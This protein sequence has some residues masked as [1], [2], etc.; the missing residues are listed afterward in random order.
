[1]LLAFKRSGLL[2]ALT[3]CFGLLLGACGDNT[4]TTAP[5]ATTAASTTAAATTSAATAAAAT[6]ASATTQAATTQAAATT[7]SATTAAAT[8]AAPTTAAASATTA[9]ASGA[10]VKLTLALDWTPNTNHTGIYVALQKGWYKDAGIDLQLLP[11]ADGTIPDVLVGQGKA[12]LGISGADSVAT[13][14]AAGQPVVSI[15]AIMQ[16][17]TSGF[18]FLKDSNIK[19]P[20]DLAGKRY[21]GFGASFEEPVIAAMIKADGGTDTKIQN[22]T[23]NVGGYQAVASKQADFVWIFAGWEGIQAKLDKVDL[24]M[25]MLKDHGIP[26]FYTPVII[27]SQ[28]DAKNKKDALKA[29]MAATAR[30]YEYAVANPKDAAD[31]LIAANPKGTFSNTDLVYQSQDYLSKQYKAE[32]PKWG[33]QTLKAWTDYPKFLYDNQVL[34]DPDGKPLTKE[35]DYSSLFT[36]DFLPQ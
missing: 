20:R 23:A 32:A 9:V 25:F 16:H 10:P 5:A 17:N 34:L 26:D 31:L 22:I 28:D 2:L 33:V 13:Y 18:A 6:T 14:R 35:L 3:L 15:A 19:R 1:M 11:Y 36:N 4:A 7:A 27:T 21:A 12:D 8:T 30:G 29:F 24:G